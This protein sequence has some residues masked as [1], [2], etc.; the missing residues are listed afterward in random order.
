MA[1]ITVLEDS[2][3]GSE[4]AVRADHAIVGR[5]FSNSSHP[6]HRPICRSLSVRSPAPR[7][8]WSGYGAFKEEVHRRGETGRK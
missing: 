3:I 6:S 1:L 5:R 2:A 4:G 7:F 8:R